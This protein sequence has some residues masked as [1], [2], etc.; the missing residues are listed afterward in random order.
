MSKYTEYIVGR[1]TD[2]CKN[3]KRRM[4]GTASA[5]AAAD[6]IADEAKAYADEVKTQDFEIHP[7]AFLKSI[8]LCV[9]MEILAMPVSWIAS[10]LEKRDCGLVPMK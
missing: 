3:Y 4:A 2:I 8:Q 1:I 7:H 10:C 6:D 9:A 5:R